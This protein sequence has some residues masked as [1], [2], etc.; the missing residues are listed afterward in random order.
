MQNGLN[1]DVLLDAL[2][3]RV[4]ERVSDRLNRSSA[5]ATMKP[6]LLTVEQAA[7]YL[8]RSK[9]SVQHMVADRT[10]PTVRHDRRVFLDIRD[11][12]E[13]IEHAKE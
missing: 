9:S 10:I 8:G 3:D 4:A 5:S 7:A 12:D 11:L 13:W 1:I 6:R 2:A